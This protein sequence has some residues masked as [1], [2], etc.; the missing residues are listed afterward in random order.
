MGN[1]I[2]KIAS[3]CQTQDETA[4]SFT[5]RFDD[6]YCSKLFA[7]IAYEERMRFF[8]EWVRYR[9]EREYIAY[10]ITSISTYSKGT[11]LA[12]W[13]YN[14]DGE[15]LAQVNMGM[16]YGAESRLPVFYP[17]FDTFRS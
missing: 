8:K 2:L 9:S 14:R 3:K 10:D 16:F 12:E 17:E 6:Q 5:D 4:I 7:S 11:D 13:G 1:L 15:N